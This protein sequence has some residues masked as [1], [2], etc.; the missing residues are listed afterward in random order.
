MATPIVFKDKHKF[1]DD[2]WGQIL[3][4]DLE[5]DVIDTPEFQRLFR[6]SQMGFVDLVYQT[7]NHTR[8]THA[9]GACH[10]SKM[11]MAHLNENTQQQSGL[12]IKISPAE[13]VLIRVG[14]LLHDITHIP[15][16]ARFRKKDAQSVL[17]S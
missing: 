14:A 4:N 8:G 12:D 3:F 13:Q 9:I 17:F 5:R 6:T 10:I 2:V 1:K 7:A 16:L 15:A 11:L